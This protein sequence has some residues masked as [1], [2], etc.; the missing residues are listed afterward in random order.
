LASD[1]GLAA[2]LFRLAQRPRSLLAQQVFSD[3]VRVAA[4]TA[5]RQ[6]SRSN[7]RTEL[8][9]LYQRQPQRSLPMWRSTKS[10]SDDA[11]LRL[12][13]IWRLSAAGCSSKENHDVGNHS[14]AENNNHDPDPSKTETRLGSNAMRHSWRQSRDRF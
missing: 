10:S 12:A 9:L 8:D 5:L 13:W 7:A 4:I 2:E 1:N 6:Q 3:D 11:T 14:K